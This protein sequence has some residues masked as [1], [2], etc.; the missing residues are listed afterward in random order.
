MPVRAL[1]E[2]IANDPETNQTTFISQVMDY[3]GFMEVGPSVVVDHACR[4]TS[5]IA[6]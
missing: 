3:S 4:L 5:D 1:I 6:G 2:G